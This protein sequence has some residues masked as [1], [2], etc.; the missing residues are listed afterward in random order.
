MLPHVHALCDVLH[1][2]K[3][4]IKG[5]IDFA[6]LLSNAGMDQYERGII[7]QGLLLLYTAEKVPD[8]CSEPTH[9]AYQV[10]RADINAMIALMYDD[11]GIEKR[12]EMFERRELALKIRQKAL[13]EAKVEKR[14]FE[15]LLF[16]S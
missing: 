15:I 14:K 7:D 12:R 16:N 6:Q 10:L 11:F 2:S 13:E 3:G 8:S 9:E 5:S 4:Q 1:A